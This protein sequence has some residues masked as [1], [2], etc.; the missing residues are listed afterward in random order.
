MLT[1]VRYVVGGSG[2]DVRI[3]GVRRV[4]SWLA[5]SVRRHVNSP[6]IVALSALGLGTIPAVFLYGTV[7]QSV[8]VA[9]RRRIHR[10]LGVAFVVLGY[11]FF[12][13][14]LM[15]LGVHLPHPMF[16][17]YQPLGGMGH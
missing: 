13:H 2:G 16:P 10:L 1:G 9:H 8:D 6:S 14:G 5:A 15:A 3:P 17:H 11:V 4:T 12:A 7:V